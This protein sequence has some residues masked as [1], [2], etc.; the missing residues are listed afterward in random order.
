MQVLQLLFHAVAQVPAQFLQLPAPSLLHLKHQLC[1]INS[2]SA[3]LEAGTCLGTGICAQLRA[4]VKL[5]LCFKDLD[6]G[7]LENIRA[8]L[9]IQ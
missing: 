5:M 4:Y 6:D 8:I 9:Q 2:E 3:S 7:M 1:L